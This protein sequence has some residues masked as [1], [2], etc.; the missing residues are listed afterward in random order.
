MSR[1]D[2]SIRSFTLDL[3]CGEC[4]WWYVH[5]PLA[6]GFIASGATIA[7]ALQNAAKAIETMDAFKQSVDQHGQ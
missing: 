5:S 2:Q 3:D 6:R 1:D 4:D 7:D